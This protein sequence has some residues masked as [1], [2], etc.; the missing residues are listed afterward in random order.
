V[1]LVVLVVATAQ[2]HAEALRSNEIS[3]VQTLIE[4]EVGCL[5]LLHNQRTAQATGGRTTS[6]FLSRINFRR[7]KVRNLV[8]MWE[9]WQLFMRDATHLPPEVNLD[10]VYGGT[11][12]WEPRGSAPVSK[13]AILFAYHKAVAERQRSK[14]EME[15]LRMDARVLLVRYTQQGLVM[16]RF[17]IENG[18]S[19]TQVHGLLLD[20]KLCQVERLLKYATKE[21]KGKGIIV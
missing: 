14:E 1:R 15:Y 16:K 5:H 6:S 21:F 3:A 19:L 18:A 11:F 12:P 10:S 17:L 8:S 13:E 7:R 2:E 4:R 9:A 20:C